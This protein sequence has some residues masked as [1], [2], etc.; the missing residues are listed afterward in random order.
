MI[1]SKDQLLQGR[2]QGSASIPSLINFQLRH[3]RGGRGIPGSRGTGNKLEEDPEWRA[4]EVL[5]LI[6]L[7]QDLQL[8]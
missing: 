2:Q 1:N 7:L 4:G 3:I 6:D 8:P 5:G